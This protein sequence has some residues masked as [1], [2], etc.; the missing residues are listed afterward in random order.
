MF[1]FT[2]PANGKFYELY[3]GKE[4]FSGTGEFRMGEFRRTAEAAGKII[5]YSY[6]HCRRTK[7][8]ESVYV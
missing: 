2:P 5:D 8:E 7:R 3:P 1:N 6:G 4:R